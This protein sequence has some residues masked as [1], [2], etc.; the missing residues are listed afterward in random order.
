MQLNGLIFP[1]PI[2]SCSYKYNSE[3][4]WIPKPI[5]TPILPPVKIQKSSLFS[6]SLHFKKMNLIPL[7]KSSSSPMQSVELSSTAPF[8]HNE[9]I[10]PTPLIPLKI[11]EITTPS[12]GGFFKREGSPAARKVKDFGSHNNLFSMRMASVTPISTKSENR[13]T[14]T[15]L[16]NNSNT[17]NSLNS[18]AIPC[19]FYEH[20]AGSNLILLHFHANAEDI[21]DSFQYMKILGNA[22]K[23]NIFLV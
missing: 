17:I 1:A 22:L 9:I 14:M 7:D 23:V 21:G 11:D 13:R 8:K 16:K 2:A 4:L 10:I 19:L 20:P 5:P 12:K 6:S 15:F 18:S 3:L